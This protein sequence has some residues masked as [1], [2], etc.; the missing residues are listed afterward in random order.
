MPTSASP[1]L[2]TSLA[3]ALATGGLYFAAFPPLDVGVVA[4]VALVP[5]LAV[6]RRLPRRGAFL[7]GWLAGT[8]GIY[9]LVAPSIH[10]AAMRYAPAHPAVAWGLALVIPQVYGALYFGVFGVAVRLAAE[11]RLSPL[12]ELALLPAAWVGCEVLRSQLGDGCPWVLLGHSQHSRL[13]LVQIADL[14]GVPAVSY[15]VALVNVGLALLLRRAGAALGAR[16]RAGVA[17]VGLAVLA[18]TWLYGAVQLQRWAQPPGP[19]LRVALVQGDVPDA[20][21]YELRRVPETLRRLGALTAQ[22]MAQRPDLVVWPENAVSV[23][24]DERASTVASAAALLAPTSV[25]VLGAPRA[26]AQGEHVALRNSA[27]AVDAGGHVTGVYDKLRLTP[28]GET[29]P[30]GLAAWFPPPAGGYSPGAELALLE[31]A[32]HRFA[33][34]IC[35][36]AIYAGLVRR[37]VNAGGEFLVNISNDGWFG[38]QPSLAQHF[39]AVLFRAVENRRF[40]LR[41]TNAG[42]T[43]IVDPRGAVVAE[44]PR[45]APAVLSGSVVPI[46]TRTFYTRAGDVFGWGC[47]A[48]AAACLLRRRGRRRARAIA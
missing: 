25:L 42:I 18:A 17:A 12:A 33:A 13:W 34:V 26:V 3:A 1:A 24:L 23:L 37:L 4:F 47:A 6:A 40:V 38:A 10:E 30:L 32:G 29:Y 16:Q 21:R 19:P 7:C 39:H 11:R 20:W 14:G 35:Y 43:A 2:T 31:V 28:F 22:A 45:A 8:V 15:M 36:E 41:G 27:F 44:A 48:L 9:A 46:A 5:L